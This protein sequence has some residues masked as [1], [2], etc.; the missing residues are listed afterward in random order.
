MTSADTSAPNRAFVPPFPAPHANRSSFLKR[1]FR[2]WHSWIHGLFVRSYTMLMGEIRMPG[3]HIFIPN[4]LHLVDDVMA[5]ARDFPKHHL[6]VEGLRPAIGIS[7]FTANGED[8]AQQRE[9]INP[10][11][12]HTGL[13]RTLPLMIAAAEDLADRIAALT[14]SG[15]SS[16]RPID[17]DPLMTHVAADIIFRTLFSVP[18]DPAGGAEIH[19]GFARFQ[20]S[21][22]SAAVLRLYR[23]PTFWHL[24]RVDR[25]AAA[26]HA[27]LNPL[28]ETRYAAFHERGEI[29]HNDI[30]QSIF[31]ARHPATGKPFTCREVLEQIS[32]IFLAGHE[33]SAS[34]MAWA[35]YILAECPDIQQAMREEVERETQG[36]PLTIQALKGMNLTRNVVRETLRLYPPVSFLPRDTTC[37]VSMRGKSVNPG[38]M[39]VIS[40]WLIQRNERNW[41]CPHAFDPSRY[42]RPE[43]QAMLKDAWLPF[44]KGPRLCVGAGFAQQEAAVVLATL[45]RRFALESPAQAKPEPVSRL[46]LRPRDGILLAFSPAP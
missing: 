44:G 30:L 21:V 12:Q 25:E 29:A 16:G 22:Q 42:E 31:E 11:F 27:I 20:R 15:A 7:T 33:T 34:L 2:S 4:E 10:A 23:L 5:R 13:A 1:F 17:I 24:R 18:I 28:V 46:T 43:G 32:L 26:I 9:M 37:P 41:P 8:W 45:V 19:T 14:G 38:D 40:P 36:G 3:L 39:L 35:S 6:L